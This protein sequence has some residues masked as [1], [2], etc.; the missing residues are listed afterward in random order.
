M[1]TEEAREMLDLIDHPFVFFLDPGHGLGRVRYRRD[2]GHYGLP[3]P[4]TNRS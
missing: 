1:T 4:T 3:E 2:D